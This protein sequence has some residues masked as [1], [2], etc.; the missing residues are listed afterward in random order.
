MKVGDE[1]ALVTVSD[2]GYLVAEYE[3]RDVPLEDFKFDLESLVGE[4]GDRFVLSDVVLECSGAECSQAVMESDVGS[5]S[6]SGV[7]D[8]RVWVSDGELCMVPVGSVDDVRE[9]GLIR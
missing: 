1:E 4:L 8:G 7:L 3:G 6:V 2:G 5:V 9:A